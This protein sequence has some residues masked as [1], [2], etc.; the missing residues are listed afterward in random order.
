MDLE[1]LL[2]RW[3]RDHHI[4]D[5]AYNA[6]LQTISLASHDNPHTVLPND[7]LQQF[8]NAEA[9]DLPSSFQQY[10]AQYG[11]FY[12][13]AQLQNSNPPPTDSTYDPTITE[14][15]VPGL[16]SLHN[17]G[18][19]D[20]NAMAVP[21]GLAPDDTPFELDLDAEFVQLPEDLQ[22]FMVRDS[23]LPINQ[24]LAR[25]SMQPKGFIEDS[26]ALSFQGHGS[27]VISSEVHSSEHV[28][29]SESDWSIVRS[30]PKPIPCIK[31][32]YDREKVWYLLLQTA[33]CQ[34]LMIR[35]VKEVTRAKDASRRKLTSHKTFV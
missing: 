30:E 17:S 25:A 20:F 10:P 33:K 34:N 31:C 9:F 1:E 35:S 27:A 23:T 4:N 11:Q 29:S 28:L 8:L 12:H 19:N 21:S 6:L 22:Y 3:R 14:G 13:P 5:D 15:L 32:W 16:H 24:Q 7:Q 2:L 26:E 18:L